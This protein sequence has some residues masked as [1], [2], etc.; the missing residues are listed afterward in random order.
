VSGSYFVNQRAKQSSRASY[1][2]DLAHR[3]WEV[4]SALVGIQQT[5]NPDRDTEDQT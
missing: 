5:P 2:S 3:L 1:D 4:S